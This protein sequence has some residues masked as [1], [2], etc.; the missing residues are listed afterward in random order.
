MANYKVSYKM[1]AKQGE[2]LKAVAKLVDGYAERVNQVRGKLGQDEMLAEVRNNL[3]KLNTQLGESRMVLN[4][5]GELLSKTVETYTGTETRQVKKVDNL[6]AHNRDF[7]KNPVTVASAGGAAGGAGAAAAQPAT[8]T[9]N[10]TDSSIGVQS[11]EV[12]SYSETTV[13]TST[14]EVTT[15]PVQTAVPLSGPAGASAAT[16]SG[17]EAMAGMA[18]GV[19]SVAGAVGGGAL[20][21]AKYLHE[22][23]KKKKAEETDKANSGSGDTYDPEIELAAALERVHMLEED[24]S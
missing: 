4:T 17:M 13:T 1:L 10:D 23:H 16:D 20:L 19:G 22:E 2:E 5:A 18:V 15:E 12:V 24:E 11:V 8:A 7:Y 9:V 3:Q 6:K 21:G 14:V